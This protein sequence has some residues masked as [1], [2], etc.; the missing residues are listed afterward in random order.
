MDSSDLQKFRD[1]Y[2]D[3]K[4]KYAGLLMNAV[5]ES[6]PEKQAG[7]VKQILDVNS[8]LAQHVR[9]FIQNS[10]GK[11]DPTVISTLTDDIIR[12]QKEFREIKHAANKTAALTKI[13]NIQK[14]DLN[15]IHFELNIWLWLFI[16]LI[17]VILVMIFRTSLVQLTQAATELVSSTSMPETEDLSESLPVDEQLYKISPA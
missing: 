17:I 3:L 10:K 16:G 1:E 13:L 2:D 4:R 5:H 11:F 8:E 12:F 15:S 14:D 9:D 7:I 6:D